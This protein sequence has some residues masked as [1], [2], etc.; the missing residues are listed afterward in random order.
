MEER[1][2]AKLHLLSPQMHPAQGRE[3]AL[4][5]NA[6]GAGEGEGWSAVEKRRRRRRGRRG[7]G[8]GTG[9]EAILHRR[10]HH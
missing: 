4:S 1:G 3:R 7:D 9:E 5:S 8:G 2:D 6:P 10:G